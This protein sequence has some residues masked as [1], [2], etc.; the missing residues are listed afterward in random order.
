MSTGQFIIDMMVYD[1]TNTTNDP[2]E[3][4]FR[5]RKELDVSGITYAGS[6]NITV[7][8]AASAVVG[9]PSTPLQWLYIE[10]D[11]TIRARFNGDSTN[12]VVISPSAAGTKDGVMFKRGT[13]TSLILNNPGATTAN[14]TVFVAY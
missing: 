13:F 11:Q 2:F 14:I 8:A 6:Q 7:T 5:W 9:L 1:D 10:T 3:S 12:N 4:I